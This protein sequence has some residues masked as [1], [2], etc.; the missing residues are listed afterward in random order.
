MKKF[1]IGFIIAAVAG[2]GVTA[3]AS[4]NTSKVVDGNS[5]LAQEISVN[6]VYC[7][8]DCREDYHDDDCKINDSKYIEMRATIENDIINEY[9]E[10]WAETLMSQYGPEWDDVLEDKYEKVYGDYAEDIVD[11]IIDSKFKGTVCDD[12]KDNSICNDDDCD[13]LD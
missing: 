2:I 13:D 11:D 6:T 1:L 10:N 12:C 4:E 8:D 7:D 3:I 9:G 5:A